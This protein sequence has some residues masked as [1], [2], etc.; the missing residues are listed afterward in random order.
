[1]EEY[2]KISYESINVHQSTQILTSCLFP[3]FKMT[4]VFLMFF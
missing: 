1:M 2:E 4:F 3:D